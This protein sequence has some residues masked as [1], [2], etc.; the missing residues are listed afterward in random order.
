[1]Q[2]ILLSILCLSLVTAC[3][4][5]PGSPAVPDDNPA[6]GFHNGA[7]KIEVCHYSKGNGSWRIINISASAWPAHEAHGDVSLD[8]QDGDGYLPDNSC[9]IIPVGDCDDTDAFVN[10]N[11][12]LE[13]A[14]D[15]DGVPGN[16]DEYTLYVPPM[17]QRTGPENGINW[18]GSGI[19]INELENK[20]TLEAALADFYGAANTRMIVENIDA[21]NFAA[22]ACA[23]LEYNGCEDWYLPALGELQAMY[24]QLGG[25]G[26]NN[27]E[28]N[29]YWSSTEADGLNAWRHIFVDGRR[30][31]SLKTI[32]TTSCR[33]VRR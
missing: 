5:E 6:L 9:G 11:N 21:A 19:D 1:M 8:D 13:V 2:K 24:D 32:G 25:T 26:N 31:S 15:P 17:D 20:T 18:G 28:G 30:G 12:L 23:N 27:F 33:C 16:G 29:A 4:K 10:P 7:D 3:E 14:V 22:K